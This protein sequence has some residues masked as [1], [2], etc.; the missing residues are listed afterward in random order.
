MKKTFGVLRYVTHEDLGLLKRE[1]KKF[2]RWVTGIG[3]RAFKD[4][5]YLESIVIPDRVTFI[6]KRAFSGCTRLKSIVLP[7]RVTFIGESAFEN[8]KYL[9]S[10]VIPDRVTFIGKSAFENCEYLESIV[11]PD[12]ITGIAVNAF[13]GC[14]RLKSIV[15]PNSVTEIG[16]GAFIDCESLKNI[17]I[18]D[19]VTKIGDGVLAGC[20]SLESIV[21]PDSVTEIGEEAFM[22]CKSL[23]SIVLPD[24]VTE[25]GEEAFMCCK[26]LESI[27]L[28]DSVTKI[29]L[30]AF[31]HCS[32]LKS[33]VLPDKITGIAVNAFLGCKSLESIVLP[34]S[35]TKIGVGAF[36]DC[37]SLKNIVI[38]DS[39]TFIG[40][41]AFRDCDNLTIKYKNIEFNPDM[42]KNSLYDIFNKINFLLK[43]KDE[44]LESYVNLIN[45]NI[46]LD[47]FKEEEI[48]SINLTRW[49]NLIKKIMPTIDRENFDEVNLK[50][51]TL[52]AK[53]LG[54]FDDESKETVKNQ[55]GKLVEMHTADLAYNFL[56]K[57]IK[58]IPIQNMHIY[59]QGMKEN[60]VNVEFLKFIS[61]KNNYEELVSKMQ[62]GNNEGL[63]TQVYEWF[64]ER[65]NLELGENEDT[66]N[67]TT[68]PTGEENRYKVRTSDVGE[69]GIEKTRWKRPTIDLLIKE[70]ASKKF[71]GITTARDSEIAEN[72]SGI[73]DYRQKHFDKAKEIDRERQESGVPDYIVGKHIGQNK[74]QAYR[75]YF[76]LTGMMRDKILKNA[77]EVMENQVDISNKIFTYDTLAKSDV[78][79]FSIGFMTSC[80]ARLYGAGAGAMRGAILSKDMQ[81]LVVKNDKDEIVAYSIMYI[82]R[83]QGYAVLNDIEV[84]KRY[85]GKEEELKIIYEKMRRCAV[86]NIEEFNK[87]AKVPVVKLNSG[88]SPNWSAVNKYIRANPQSPILKA[89]NFNDFKYAGSGSWAGDWHREQYTIWQLDEKEK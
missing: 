3:E 44:N 79:N 73:S 6:G 50:D 2:W 81:P 57:F 60:G 32:S 1:P 33:I 38:P 17:V 74:T 76:E 5:E 28:P 42:I 34:G 18:P 82:N 54:L 14:K 13:R 61:N 52:L 11:I 8:C 23:E 24:S 22:C 45:H 31:A 26:S 48:R 41:G 20:T 67:L 84:N 12:K 58:D 39:V 25:I 77:Q 68:L 65:G 49:D 72:F 27:V 66:A 63:L 69:N 59:L 4:C 21:L 35:V 75:E 83:E 53:N 16:V 87:R 55:S 88:L 37:K 62:N 78:A 70:F 46:A 64:V 43:V 51:F 10:I 40:E 15:I 85:D 19:S 36:I 71:T 47:L 80:C 56:Q 89:P 86:E 7:D 29:G 30:R 9:E